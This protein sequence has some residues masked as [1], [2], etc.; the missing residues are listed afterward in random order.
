MGS[1]ALSL[2]VSRLRRRARHTA[3]RAR[4]S[5]S[6]RGM[7][8]KYIFYPCWEAGV[9]Q[10]FP[11]RREGSVR[12]AQAAPVDRV[13][14]ARAVARGWGGVNA[15]HAAHVQ[16]L[17]GVC[18]GGRQVLKTV[19]LCVCMGGGGVL[20]C[21]VPRP[22]KGRP[23]VSS[24]APTG[25]APHHIPPPHHHHTHMRRTHA[26]AGINTHAHPP[27]A[28]RGARAHTELHHNMH[29]TH[30]RVHTH[31]HC[32]TPYTLV[33]THRAIPPHTPCLCH[34]H[35]HTHARTLTSKWTHGCSVGA[36]R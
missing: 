3:C 36:N 17:R 22:C 28:P 30:T 5:A 29:T 4:R 7:P 33:H 1:V 35:G 2:W 13:G 25:R 19:G 23:H 16:A 11:T 10:A 14:D 32:T 26:N 31:V 8:F 18:G 12:N 20:H 6:E 21:F 9:C 15:V 27:H 34:T 24:D